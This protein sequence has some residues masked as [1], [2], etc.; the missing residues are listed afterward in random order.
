MARI[1]E[2][3]KEANIFAMLLLMPSQFIKEDM[4]SG[5]DLGSDTALDELAKKYDVPKIAIAA[6]IGYY[7]KHGY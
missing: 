2:V 6:R 3:E 5:I 7:M 1:P 4:K